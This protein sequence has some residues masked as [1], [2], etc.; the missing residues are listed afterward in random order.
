MSDTLSLQES[1][2]GNTSLTASDI[3]AA[4]R[5]VQCR[6]RPD[7]TDEDCNQAIPH[8]IHRMFLDGE[9]E[10]SRQVNKPD[11][12]FRREWRDS[13]ALHHPRWEHRFWDAKAAEALLREH[14]PWF[15]E[16]Y[17]SYTRLVMRSDAMRVFIM[18]H[19]GGIYLD[20]DVECFR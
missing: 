13:C 12:S 7:G 16:T 18:H 5:Q 6:R 10:Y 15:L 14:Y 3:V 9:E 4:Q 19:Y 8:I 1:P 20:M 11:P 17:K 2:T